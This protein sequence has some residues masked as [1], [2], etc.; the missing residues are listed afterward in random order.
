VRLSNCLEPKLVA[1][2]MRSQALLL[3]LSIKDELV[4]D[5]ARVNS[6][7]AYVTLGVVVTS[8]RE[9]SRQITNLRHPT[10]SYLPGD[11]H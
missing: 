5:F 3:S 1:A 2:Q 6:Y 4:N 8:S 9:D 11:A 7:T 10:I